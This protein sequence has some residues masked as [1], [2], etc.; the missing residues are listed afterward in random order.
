MRVLFDH[1]TPAP[2]RHTLAGHQVA[3][4]YERGWSGLKNGELIAAAE[5]GEFEVLVTTD[6]NLRYQQNLTGRE[7]AIVVLWTTSWPKI[8]Q[9]L[10]K[11]QSAV[12]GAIKGSYVEIDP[13]EA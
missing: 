12:D 1:G 8:Q 11:V 5:A 3:T 2:L 6:K 4:A 10:P 13:G 7:L 9:A